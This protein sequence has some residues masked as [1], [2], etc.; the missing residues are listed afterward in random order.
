MPWADKKL[1][2]PFICKRMDI[3]TIL[4]TTAVSLVGLQ[5]CLP[6]SKVDEINDRFPRFWCPN[7]LL[8]IFYGLSNLCGV[9]FVLGFAIYLSITQH[10]WYIF[11]YLGAAAISNLIVVSLLKT[12]LALMYINRSSDNSLFIRRMMGSLLIVTGIVLCFT[13]Q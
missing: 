3:T 11:A 9:I 1:L 10:W 5:L 6:D 7:P 8:R 12:I 4:W 13:L 2:T